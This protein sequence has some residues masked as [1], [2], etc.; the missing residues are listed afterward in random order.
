MKPQRPFSATP[1]LAVAPR[2]VRGLSLV[3]TLIAMSVAALTLGVALPG[4]DSVR[5]R[6]HLE[7]VASQLETDLQFARSLAVAQHRSLRISFGSDAAGSCYVVHSGAADDCR[8]SADGPVCTAGAEAERH[9]H[10]GPDVPVTL[11][12]NVRSM[13]FDAVRGTVTPTGTVRVVGRDGR[14]VHQVVSV[15]GRVRSCA[16]A[17]GLPGYRAC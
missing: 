8:C 13:L 9:V 16:P 5:E 7:G 12:A 4:F 6:R 11:N 2:R 3:E 14:A 1:Q 17:P 10:L 15:M